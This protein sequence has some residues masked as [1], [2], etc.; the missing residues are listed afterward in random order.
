LVTRDEVVLATKAGVARRGA[1]RQV[2]ASRRTLLATL[3]VAG[4]ART[5]HLDPG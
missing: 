2:D 5:D 3:D 4:P 1:Q